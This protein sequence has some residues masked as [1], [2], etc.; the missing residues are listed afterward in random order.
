MVPL[1]ERH[2]GTAYRLFERHDR[3]LQR[4]LNFDG[5]GTHKQIEAESLRSLKWRR[6]AL[7]KSD[8]HRRLATRRSPFFIFAIN[9]PEYPQKLL[10]YCF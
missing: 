8:E 1:E 9:P 5:R 7:R 4:S 2:W 10:K 3:L 6:W